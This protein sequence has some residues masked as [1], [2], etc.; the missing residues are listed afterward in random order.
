M[1]MV[2]QANAADAEGMGQVLEALL[3]AGRR[4]KPGD[5]G[6][7]RAHYLEHPDLIAIM[8]AVDPSGRIM[9]FQSLKRAMPGNELGVTPGWGIIGTHVHPGATRRGVGRKLFAPTRGAAET[10]GL[11]RVEA[12]IG[13]TNAGALAYY[14]AMGFETW[15]EGDGLVRQVLRLD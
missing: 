7:A 3:A 5:T 2:R 8:V 1:V 4:Q 15:R 12:T 6:F 11:G 10:A 13:R 14:R 9:G